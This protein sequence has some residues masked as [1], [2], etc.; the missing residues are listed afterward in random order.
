M[1]Q[2]ACE[3]RQA[4]RRNIDMAMIDISVVP[5]GTKSASVSK[6][7]AGA[8]K[9]VKN[10]P[11]IKYRLTPMNTIIEGDLEQLLS[12]AKKMH[13]SAFSG[14]VTRVVTTIRIDERR[15]KALTMEGKI[16]AVED[17]LE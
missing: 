14:S 10:E 1:V 8:L 5:V 9:I 6:F 17:K 3:G 7:V 2:S 13:D 4:K 11:G 15:D 12:L 16:K